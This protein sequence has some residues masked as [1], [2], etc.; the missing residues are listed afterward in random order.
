MMSNSQSSL[1]MKSSEYSTV[2]VTSSSFD[3]SA[4]TLG[5]NTSKVS[6]TMVLQQSSDTQQSGNTTKSVVTSSSSSN[7]TFFI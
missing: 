7:S 1:N 3:T 2:R 6:T 5:S 4:N